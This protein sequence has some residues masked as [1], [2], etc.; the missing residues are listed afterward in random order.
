M[1]VKRIVANIETKKISAA[2]RFYQKVLGL[3]LLMDHG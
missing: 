1:K 2:K 3:D